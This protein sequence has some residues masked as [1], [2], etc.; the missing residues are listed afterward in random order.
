MSASISHPSMPLASASRPWRFG[1][2]AASGEASMQWL[3][4]RNC[5][6]S[7][8]QML[9]FF[10]A[11]CLLSL[12]IAGFFWVQGAT[13]VMPFAWLEMA[14]IGT[15]LLVYARHAADSENIRLHPGSLCIEHMCGGRL[16]RVEFVP[17]WVRVEPEHGERSLIELSGQGRRNSGRRRH[18]RRI[19]RQI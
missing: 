17:A 10:A 12:A 4:K 11:T 14:A 8:R 3:L 13:L 6:A 16:E 19:T 15:A 9:A 5:S 2:A 1:V 18:G 7:P